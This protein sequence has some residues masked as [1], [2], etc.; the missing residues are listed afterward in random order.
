[1]NKIL[2]AITAV[3][4]ISSCGNES[5]NNKKWTTSEP[6]FGSRI[7]DAWDNVA[8]KDPSIVE[9]NGKYH[10]FYTAKSADTINGKVN[11]KIGTGYTSAKTI[12]ELNSS[13]RIFIDS[14][15]G[16]NV[17]APQVFYFEPQK[18]WYLIAHTWVNGDH[19]DLEPIYMTNYN[20]ED[21]NGWSEI[22]VMDTHKTE[23]KFW[24]DFWA[25]QDK[26]EMYMFYADQ[27]G[28]LLYMKS[29][30]E[31]FPNGFHKSESKVAFTQTGVKDSL[32]WKMFEAAHVFYSKKDEKFIALGEGA[33]FHPTR[34]WDVDARNRFIFAM[35]ADSIDG[36]W[37]R[38]EGDKNDF[39]A[40]AED[41]YN[42][43]GSKSKN[44]LVSHPELIR[45]SYNQKLEIESIE[46]I[47]M[48][49]QSFDA[50]NIPATYN[51][52]ELP[53]KLSLMSKK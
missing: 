20:I 44:S 49:Y 19:G 45:A 25:I 4:M 39:F 23:K 18:K 29:S 7:G 51:Y 16:G 41:V 38:Y 36:E 40:D 37:T 53:L 47:Q 5:V 32:K 1:M 26:D 28:A 12:E 30:N 33:Y 10:L 14:I 31:D 8:A 35:V 52:N 42:A 15:V 21:V 50:T 34:K 6:V 9:Y 48:L 13:E 43:D 17:V 2:I 27:K 11:Y 22:K 24:I 3:L 46:E